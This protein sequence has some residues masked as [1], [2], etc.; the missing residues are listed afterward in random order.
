MAGELILNLHCCA[1]PGRNRGG[2][3][4]GDLPKYML[5]LTIHIKFYRLHD[6]VFKA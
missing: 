2:L 5:Q 4:A 1:T 3:R 6:G